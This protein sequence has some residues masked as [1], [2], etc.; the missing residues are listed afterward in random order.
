MIIAI[1]LLVINRNIYRSDGCIQ[2]NTVPN[3]SCSQQREEESLS[4]TNAIFPSFL[5]V[6]STITLL[7]TVGFSHIKD[8]KIFVSEHKS[9]E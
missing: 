3:M 9:R 7:L 1:N 6:F 2:L 8:M 5:I 4:S